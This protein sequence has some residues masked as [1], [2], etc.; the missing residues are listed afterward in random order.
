MFSPW[1]GARAQKRGP[2]VLRSTL[3]NEH[4]RIKG[5]KKLY[6]FVETIQKDLDDC[7]IHYNAKRP[8]QGRNINGRTS[9]TIF[10]EGLKK[11]KTGGKEKRRLL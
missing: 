6:E 3:S 11:I 5:R 2:A 8:H 4:L 1:S 9:E 7:L 10:K